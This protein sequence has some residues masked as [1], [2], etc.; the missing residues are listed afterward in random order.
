VSE[1]GIAPGAAM[2]ERTSRNNKITALVLASI[3]AVFFFG[4]MLK[5]LLLR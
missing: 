3:V 5:Y 4:I 2:D 1:H